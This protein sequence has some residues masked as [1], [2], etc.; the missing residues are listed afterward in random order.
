MKRF[1]LKFLLANLFL[2]LGLDSAYAANKAEIIKQVEKRLNSIN[3]LTAE[4]TQVSADGG[5]S[6]GRFFLARPGKLRWQYDPPVPLLIIGNYGQ[7]QYSDL[8]LDTVSYA[9]MDSTL[10]GLMARGNIVLSGGD[11]V[12]TSVN[13]AQGSVTLNMNKR[14]KPDEGSLTLIFS[15][16]PLMLRKMEVVDA[17]KQKTVISLNN[18]VLDTPLDRKLFE[19]EKKVSDYPK[20]R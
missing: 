1:I 4:F 14:G 7:I 18:A 12:V 15:E 9:D 19:F 16:N 17:A 11:I 6:S 10:A 8:E 2:C 3:T 5:I 13:V 20:V